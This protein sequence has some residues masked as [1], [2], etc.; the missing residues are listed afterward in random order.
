MLRLW[1]LKYKVQINLNKPV[2]LDLILSSQYGAWMYST[3]FNEIL[4][5]SL[6]RGF[7]SGTGPY[8]LKDWTQ[9]TSITLERFDNYWN[10]NPEKGYFEKS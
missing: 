2:P 9:S 3:K 4:I 1:G 10:S 7:A 5:D 8:Y 6:R